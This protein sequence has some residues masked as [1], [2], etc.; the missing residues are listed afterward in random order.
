MGETLLQIRSEKTDP[1]PRTP[2][3]RCQRAETRYAL[4]KNVDRIPTP[5]SVSF[6]ALSQFAKFRIQQLSSLYDGLR[7]V[8]QNSQRYH[9]ACG[10]EIA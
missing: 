7:T 4:K 9:T 8:I 3:S 5:V 2:N 10:S 1:V 6:F